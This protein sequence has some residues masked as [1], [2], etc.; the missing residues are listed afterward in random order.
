VGWVLFRADS[1]PTAQRFLLGLVAFEGMQWIPVLLL[2]VVLAYALVI[3][4]DSWPRDRAA[5]VLIPAR[6]AAVAA[7]AGLLLLAAAR[8]G[9][10]RPF[11]Y[12][13]F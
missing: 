8:G 9:D 2:P 5:G 13:Q 10:V 11:L 7:V 12:G 1:F 6:I 4:L 3:L